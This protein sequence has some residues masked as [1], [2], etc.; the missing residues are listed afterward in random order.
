[1]KNS[2]LA[3]FTAIVMVTGIANTTFA[4]KPKKHNSKIFSLE[5]ITL[6][7]WPQKIL[8]TGN[9]TTKPIL[10]FIHGGPGFTEMALVMKYNQN[11]NNHFIVVN[12]DQRGTAL[13][14]K[15]SIP[16]STMTMEQIIADG[17]DLTDSL[18]K[19]FHRQKIFLVG[20]SFGTYIAT[21]MAYRYPKDYYAYIGIGQAAN[22]M[23]NERVSLAYTIKMAKAAH[24]QKAI[25]DLA[26]LEK[27]FPQK[28]TDLPDLYL[29]R[30]WLAYFGGAVW[31]HHDYNSLYTSMDTI[32]KGIYNEQLAEE[33]ENFTMDALWAQAMTID[34]PKTV[35]QLKV[36]VYFMLGRHDYNAPYPLAQQ[37][38]N[39]LKAP[40]KKLIMFE[41]SAHLPCFEEPKKFNSIMAAIAKTAG[42]G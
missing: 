35:P 24:N 13:S 33:S 34:L 18:K 25:N 26:A 3:L 42:K 21:T 9:D 29:R 27:R 30:K 17:H 20:H 6:G 31:K 12:W 40:Y 5:S 1:M 36:P 41:N 11:L 15:P 38:F 39:K 23:D 7:G 32:H 37:Y 22:M 4:A 19:R 10:I 28:S 8:I 16:K 14:Y 2:I